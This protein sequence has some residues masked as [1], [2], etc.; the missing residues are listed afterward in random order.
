MT[1][2]NILLFLFCIVV[3]GLISL[4]LGQDIGF[5]INNYH[6]YIPYAFLHGRLFTD[7]I[8]AGPVHTFFNPLPD[9]PFFLL[10]YYLNDWPKVT[11]FLLGG[12][13]GIFLFALFK[14]VPLVLQGNRCQDK[15]LQWITVFFAATG[16]A[17]FLQVGHSSNEELMG[18]LAVLAAYL[19]FRGTDEK[20]HFNLKNI[21]WAA[22]WASLATGLKHTAAPAA[23]GIG[24]ACLFLL[25]K[26]KSS[27]KQYFYVIG[28]ALGGFLLT[29]GYFLWEKYD[30]L[31]NPLFPFFNHIFH[32]PF[33]PNEALA[34]S[35]YV[36]DGWKEWL[37]LPFLRVTWFNNWDYVVDFR[38]IL[39]L[40]SVV[41]L[42]IGGL[43]YIKKRPLS[44]TYALLLCFFI[45]TY[46]PWVILFGNLRYGIFLEVLS[47]LLFVF[48]LRRFLSAK[49]VCVIV[50]GILFL[51]AFTPFPRFP[52]TPYK[53]KNILFSQSVSMEKNSLVVVVGHISFVIPF[54]D[55]SA[56]YIGG[57]ILTKEFLDT[58]QGT[59]N[60]VCPLQYLD[61]QHF[62]NPRIYET[63]QNHQGAIYILMPSLSWLM[64]EPFWKTYG[65]TPPTSCQLL[66]TNIR[67]NRIYPGDIAL[68]RVEKIV[69]N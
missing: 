33:Y 48:L 15:C 55:P 3:G 9:I 14:W 24:T 69:K 2:K 53:H 16:M 65:L 41:L 10:F 49:F 35:S 52:R 38:L 1:I 66:Q 60:Y 57:V 43:F 45:G 26:N 31:Q 30:K 20:L 8:A 29:D 58:D 4:W 56:K 18:F 67:P 25:I 47:S 22:F 51:S 64:S 7:I 6:L 19:I 36:P 34:N 13:Y 62:F 61:Y 46:V 68:C 27:Y 59:L 50:V 32:S 17:A 40:T 28:A 54:L 44:K 12:Y 39:G 11:G 23:I 21:L 42:I 5:D 37:F 63:I